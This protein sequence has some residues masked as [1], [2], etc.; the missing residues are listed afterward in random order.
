MKLI[1]SVFDISEE[2]MK[3]PK[4]VHINYDRIAYLANKMLEEGKREF[5][6]ES[7]GE[8]EKEVV[9]KELIAS[10]I[11]YC[12]WYGS[13]NIRPNGC[14]SGKMYEV[15]NKAVDTHNYNNDRLETIKSLLRTSLAVGRFPLLEERVRHIDEIISVM[16][17]G[18][19][20][21]VSTY[22]ELDHPEY[23]YFEN[24]ISFFPGFA[25]DIF[26]KRASLFFLQLYRTFGWFEELVHYLHIPADYQV[27][28]ILRGFGAIEY[29][30]PLDHMVNYGQLIE[31]GSIMECE[32]RAATI[33]VC[34]ELQKQLGWNWNA[35]DVDGWLW[36][37]RKE[38]DMPFHLTITTDY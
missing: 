4:Y 15:V 25:S 2:F 11:N 7:T 24:L 1:D 22:K 12:Y 32:I 5:I 34:E 10:S 14:S 33:L 9:F 20:S 18:Y 17:Y 23:Y 19:A 26:L 16:G 37:R 31:K 27:P 3:S 30:A 38:V 21:V 29:K 36:L 8:K 6:T 28:K 13:S 35:A